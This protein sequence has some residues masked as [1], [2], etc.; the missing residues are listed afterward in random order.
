MEIKVSSN[1]KEIVFDWL[2]LFVLSEHVNVIPFSAGI[3]VKL[4]NELFLQILGELVLREISEALINEPHVHVGDWVIY[5]E[6]ILKIHRVYKLPWLNVHEETLNNHQSLRHGS[7]LTSLKVLLFKNVEKSFLD[8]S[9]LSDFHIFSCSLMHFIHVPGSEL[10]FRIGQELRVNHSVG[11]GLLLYAIHVWVGETNLVPERLPLDKG[12]LLFCFLA[13]V[14]HLQILLIISQRIAS[15]KDFNNLV[16][17][18]PC[19]ILVWLLNKGHNLA[20]KHDF[21]AELIDHIRFVRLRDQRNQVLRVEG[22]RCVKAV[23]VAQS[24]Q[25]LYRH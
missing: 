3:V 13:Q 12:L 6:V 21:L 14:H 18:Q 1:G 2:K 22:L 4:L 19:S 16:C 17:F 24:V 10:G 15:V 5:V 9:Y 7:L 25:L 23:H 20:V 8:C 11:R